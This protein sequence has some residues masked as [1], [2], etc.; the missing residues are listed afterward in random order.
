MPNYMVRVELHNV[1]D[2]QALYTRLHDAMEAKGFVRWIKSS[3]GVYFHLPRGQYRLDDSPLT[4]RLVARLA[5]SIATSVHI[6]NTVFASTYTG[7][8][9]QGLRFI[10]SEERKKIRLRATLRRLFPGSF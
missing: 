10:S 3:A 4:S 5:K 1:D 2:E 7:W 9:A 6:S 8:S